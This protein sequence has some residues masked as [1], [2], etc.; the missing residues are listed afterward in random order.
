MRVPRR[1]RHGG[2][3]FRSSPLSSAS[4][5]LSSDPRPSGWSA[6]SPR[7]SG[8][9]RWV[10]AGWWR[11]TT[12]VPLVPPRHEPPPTPGATQA[13]RRPRA[14][15]PFALSGGPK[16][17]LSPC[18]RLVTRRGAES[19][20]PVCMSG[21]PE[22]GLSPAVGLQIGFQ[23]GSTWV[24]GSRPCRNCSLLPLVVRS[25]PWRKWPAHD[26]YH[27]LG[28]RWRPGLFL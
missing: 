14:V 8:T 3:E 25:E 7:G 1:R 5:V 20:R 4:H 24:A 6:G 18:P 16:G 22:L 2:L 23:L 27:L 11:G 26:F 21:L 12:Q 10:S 15:G 28:I 13:A 17:D 19:I 9:E